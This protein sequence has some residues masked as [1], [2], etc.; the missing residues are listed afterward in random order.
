MKSAFLP[1]EIPSTKWLSTESLPS[2]STANNR[3]LLCSLA[4]AFRQDA[5]EHRNNAFSLCTPAILHH[6]LYKY[7]N[8]ILQ[9][10]FSMIGKS[11]WRE[12]LYLLTYDKSSLNR[13]ALSLK[14]ALD[15]IQRLLSGKEKARKM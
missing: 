12:T 9:G 6:I 3:F 15:E 1:R 4:R 2:P 13:K 14:K 5:K 7:I 8:K 11:K 10:D